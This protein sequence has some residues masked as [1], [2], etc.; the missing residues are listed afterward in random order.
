MKILHIGKYFSPIEGG[1]E[2]INKV[3]VDSLKGYSQRIISFNNKANTVEEDANGIPILRSATEGVFSS[4]PLSIRY[5]WDLRRILKYYSPD[6]IHF[7]YPNPLI[8]IYLLILLNSNTKL[9][10]HWHSDVVAQEN[11]KKFIGPTENK[12]LKRADIIITTS[13]NYK[14]YSPTLKPFISKIKV[15]PCSID[16]HKFEIKSEEISRVNEI[17]ERYNNLPIVFFVGR[18]VEYKGLR[19]LLDSEKF[20]K[21]NCVFLIGGNGPLTKE[22]KKRYDSNRIVWLGRIPDED[23]KFFYRA[24]DVFAFPSI[25]RNEAFGVVLTEAMYCEVPTVTF[26]IEGSGVNWVSIDRITGLE[27]E[28]RNSREFAKAI[29]TLL[30]NPR[31]RMNLGTHGKERVLELFSQDVVAE[32]YRKLYQDIDNNHQVS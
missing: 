25:T 5:F 22:L 31:I 21:S 28:N 3:I 14:Y 10:V 29:E 11:L 13:E 2:S 17:K 12:L 16:T 19:Y 27:V 23:L 15:I 9:I 26:K 32:R 7:H 1:I 24:A 30:Q 6:V 4:Q 8:A 18:H 20:V